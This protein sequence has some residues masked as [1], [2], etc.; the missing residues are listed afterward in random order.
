MTMIDESELR[1][2]FARLRAA[3]LDDTPSF[4]DI[5]ALGRR[6]GSH[7]TL[8]VRRLVIGA[9]G[10]AAVAVIWLAHA[11][12]HSSPTAP[13]IGTWRAPTDVLLS[14]PGSVPFRPV[15]ALGASVVDA[16]LS[17]TPMKGA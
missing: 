13:S 5:A 2:R 12:S 8:R 3:D 11:R 17:P 4:A 16:M 6:H 9:M 10:I 7:G 1:R 15:P 14:T